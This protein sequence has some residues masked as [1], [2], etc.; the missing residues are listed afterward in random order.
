M[1][2]EVQMLYFCSRSCLSSSLQDLVALLQLPDAGKSPS[3][4]VCLWGG[5]RPGRDLRAQGPHPGRGGQGGGGGGHG[6][7]HV[8]HDR[9]R[10]PAHAEDQGQQRGGSV[11]GLNRI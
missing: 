4:E 10:L 7:L 5:D 11:Q 2:A 3:P 6:G 9:E 1:I 8:R